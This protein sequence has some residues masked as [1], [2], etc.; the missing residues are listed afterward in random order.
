MKSSLKVQFPLHPSLLIASNYRADKQKNTLTTELYRLAHTVTPPF[1]LFTAFFPSLHRF[2]VKSHCSSHW[3]RVITLVATGLQSGRGLG[4]TRTAIRVLQKPASV[5][6]SCCHG[7]LQLVQP[8]GISLHKDKWMIQAWLD[9]GGVERGRQLAYSVVACLKWRVSMQWGS[10]VR[11][12]AQQREWHICPL[13]WT[14]LC[15]RTSEQKMCIF[16]PGPQWT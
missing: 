4:L 9:F 2:K 11:G 3:F 6:N 1:S 15:G 16:H 7:V 8:F 13:L 5:F 12:G 14:A 10:P